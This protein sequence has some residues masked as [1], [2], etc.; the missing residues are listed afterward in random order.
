MNN[1]R[2]LTSVEAE[3]G[4]VLV[5]ALALSCIIGTAGCGGGAKGG[6]GNATGGSPTG[7]GGAGAAASGG[8][9]GSQDSAGSGGSGG[10]QDSEVNRGG[11]GAAGAGS[12]GAGAV[13]DSGTA[14]SSSAVEDVPAGT[15]CAR[16]S[17]LQ[18]KAEAA[19]C[20]S[21][22]R[23]VDACKLAMANKCAGLY[24]DQASM[25]PLSGYVPSTTGLAMAEFQ[26]RAAA[27]D[28]TIV[29]W[30]ASVSGLRGIFPGTLSQ[31]GDCTPKNLLDSAD[32]AS[33]LLACKSPANTACLP[34]GLVWKC[35]ARASVGGACFSDTNCQSGLY[36]DNPQTALVGAT[37]KTAKAV[38]ASCTTG[39]QCESLVCKGS[40]C[41]VA[42]VQSVY[43]LS[44]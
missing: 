39:S 27:C 35:T 21:P 24:L 41:V 6:K 13:A 3:G 14:D 26:R 1:T 31:G 29:T 7:A 12:G 5:C 22:G 44:N 15:V 18:C 32:A 25:S 36:C 43:C 34:G 17:G 8:S 38:G 4:L 19:C 23:S 16:L 20:T 30:G 2:E 42:D 33:H 9:G 11:G 10:S 40:A 28:P 37:C